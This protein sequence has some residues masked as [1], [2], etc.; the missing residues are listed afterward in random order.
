LRK[1]TKSAIPTTVEK[2]VAGARNEAFRIA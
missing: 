1:C 2:I